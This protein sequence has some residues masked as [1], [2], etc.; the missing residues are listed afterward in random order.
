MQMCAVSVYAF[1]CTCVGVGGGDMV[2]VC[3]WAVWAPLEALR[4]GAAQTLWGSAGCVC[5][6]CDCGCSTW[7]YPSLHPVSM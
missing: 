4:C 5:G 1:R 6:V 3:V 2:F 7:A